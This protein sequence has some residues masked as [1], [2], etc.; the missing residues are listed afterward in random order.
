MT[1]TSHKFGRLLR[2]IKATLEYPL[3]IFK[4]CP[5]PDNHVAKKRRIRK[6]AKQFNC[7]TFME[8]GTFYGQMVNFALPFFK[9]V[10]SVEL[11]EPLFNSNVRAFSG[12]DQIELFL[13]NSADQLEKMIAKSQGRILF[14]LDGHF[15][16][17]GTGCGDAVS[18]ILLELDVIRRAGVSNSCILIDDYRLF[19][20]T[21]G[22]P[23]TDET[24]AALRKINEKYN[25]VVD[26]DCLV[27]TPAE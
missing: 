25:V 20:G 5:A 12:N 17:A 14:W 22:Y 1:I 21:D 27:A 18:P 9:K 2:D 16:G 19:T 3:W 23:T 15:S 10:M 13:G 11:Y 4:G 7:T 26:G 8:T 6:L 24:N